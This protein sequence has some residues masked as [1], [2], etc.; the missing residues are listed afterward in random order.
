M[1]LSIKTKQ[2]AG[3]TVIVG[4]ALAV[5]SA[6]YVRSLVDILLKDSRA[7]AWST[8]PSWMGMAWSWPTTKSRAWAAASIPGGI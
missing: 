4:L 5:L 7:R 2:V 8:R 1:R 3:V 6:W